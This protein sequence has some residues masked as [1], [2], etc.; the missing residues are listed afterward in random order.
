MVDGHCVGVCKDE[1]RQRCDQ[2]AQEL[3]E[4]A[5]P[6][7]LLRP[8]VLIGIG[9]DLFPVHHLSGTP[10]VMLARRIELT[11]DGTVHLTVIAD[12]HARLPG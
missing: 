11:G 6:H 3:E 4:P 10:D 7:R 12:D 1:R 9:R 5:V 8:K 2:M